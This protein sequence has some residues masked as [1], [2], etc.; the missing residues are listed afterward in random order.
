MELKG[1]LHAAILGHAVGDALGVPVEFESRSE[2]TLCPVTRMIGYGSYDVPAGTWSDDTSM[3]LATL[4][5]LS[6][7]LDYRDLMERFCRWANDAEYTPYHEVF[8]MGIATRNALLRY[9]RGEADPLQCGGSGEYDNGNGSLMRILPA[10]I[11]TWAKFSGKAP[12]PEAL[13]VIYN[14]SSLTHAHLRSKM[15]CGIFT[16]IVYSLLETPKKSAVISALSQANCHYRRDDEFRQEIDYFSRLFSDTFIRLPEDE[17]KSTGYVV[18][19]LEAAIWCLLTT[20][21]YRECVLK[22]VNLGGDTDTVAAIAGGLAGILYGPDA[23][24]HEWLEVLAK[25]EAIEDLCD[26][27]YRRAI[28]P[29]L[30]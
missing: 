3:T 12:C 28:C 17:I 15:A 19:T 18:D 30:M 14:I 27:F 1:I 16:F 9:L 21:N 8:D 13:D 7:G 6:C 5:S 26:S 22:A 29:A 25:R 4:D 24:P 2:L 11:W 23:I 20:N 10:A